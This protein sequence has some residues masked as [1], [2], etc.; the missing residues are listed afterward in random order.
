MYVA[1]AVNYR[2]SRL[3]AGDCEDI[4]DAL[5]HRAR[6]IR[7]RNMGKK[8]TVR[9]SVFAYDNASGQGVLA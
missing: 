3:G 5:Q 1:I 9:H 6:D 8:W 7:R 2:I 4:F